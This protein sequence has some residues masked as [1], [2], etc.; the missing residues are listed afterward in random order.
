[1]LFKILV[2]FYWIISSYVLKIFSA[3]L[4]HKIFDEKQHFY[5]VFKIEG[6]FKSGINY[7]NLHKKYISHPFVRQILK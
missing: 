1:M 5:Y 2:I 7:K 4:L 3:D 6:D